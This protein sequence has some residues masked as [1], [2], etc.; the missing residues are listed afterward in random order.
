MKIG[1]AA[2]NTVLVVGIQPTGSTLPPGKLQTRVARVR[3]G[4]CGEPYP[5]AILAWQTAPDFTGVCS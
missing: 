5:L 1:R 3:V 2:L 4:I